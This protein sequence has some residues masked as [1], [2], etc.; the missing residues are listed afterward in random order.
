MMLQEPAVVITQPGSLIY[1]LVVEGGYEM[2]QWWVATGRELVLDDPDY[3]I[4]RAWRECWFDTHSLL[5]NYHEDPHQTRYD[6]RI[7][8]GCW[9]EL[10]ADIFVL[11]VFLCDGFLQITDSFPESLDPKALRFFRIMRSLP[12]E[13]QMIVCHRAVGSKGT[14]IAAKVAELAFRLL[15]RKLNEPPKELPWWRKLY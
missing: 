4:D 15:A 11:V 9:N 10:A 2:L 7:E 13:L 12:M 14:V 8:L 5:K 1:S 6:V 3:L